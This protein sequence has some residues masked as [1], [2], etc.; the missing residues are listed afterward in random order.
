MEEQT[1]VV[2]KKSAEGL[3]LDLT[4][5]PTDLILALGAMAT[6]LANAFAHDAN[7][8][9]VGNAMNLTG[10]GVALCKATTTGVVAMMGVDKQ[11]DEEEC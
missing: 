3:W 8:D 11:E 5:E 9:D 10:L 7:P 6:Q 2:I 1:I 4:G